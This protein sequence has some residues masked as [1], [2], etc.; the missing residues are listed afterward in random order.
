MQGQAGR[1][2]RWRW[3]RTPGLVSS[4]GANSMLPWVFADDSSVCRTRP[5]ASTS[6]WYFV[7]ALPRSVGF[8]PVSSP[9]FRPHRQLAA[10]PVPAPSSVSGAVAELGWQVAPAAVRVQHEQDAYQRGPLIDPRPPART[11]R[12]RTPRQQRLDQLPEPVL[13]LPLLLCARHDRAALTIT[14][15]NHVPTRRV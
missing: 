4:S 12:H 1:P 7:P 14:E 3:A 13:N 9:P 8:R 2:S 6:R 11:L 5:L 15:R 10:R